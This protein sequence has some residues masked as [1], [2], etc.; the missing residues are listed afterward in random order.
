MSCNRCILSWQGFYGNKFNPFDEDTQKSI[1]TM[2]LE[3]I[4]LLDSSR[5][6]LKVKDFGGY[7]VEFVQVPRSS[8]DKSFNSL[9]AMVFHERPPFRCALCTRSFSVNLCILLACNS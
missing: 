9:P 8:S 2:L 4:H 3:I 1:C 7:N 6:G 5:E